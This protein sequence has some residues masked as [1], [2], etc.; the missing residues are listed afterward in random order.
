MGPADLHWLVNEMRPINVNEMRCNGLFSVPKTGAGDSSFTRSGYVTEGHKT[1]AGDSSVTSGFFSCSVFL[2]QPTPL[3]N[4]GAGDS[5]FTR[6]GYETE[7]HKTGAGDSSF[8][9]GK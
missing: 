6:S 7:G 1:G 3:H 8:R 4:T 5:S 2:L 9:H